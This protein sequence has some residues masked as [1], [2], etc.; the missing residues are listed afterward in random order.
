MNENKFSK[1]KPMLLKEIKEPFNNS[2]YLYELKFDGTRTLIYI[3]NNNILIK[4]RRNVILN[5]VYPELLEIKNITKDKCIFDG[6][7]ILTINGVPNFSKLQERA[8]L[9]NKYKIKYMEDNYPVT[10]VC[11][12][13]LYKNKD[14]TNLT[15]IERKNILNKFK[16]TN[17]FIKSIVYNDGINL[18]KLV[19]LNNLEGIVAKE[20]TSIYK[21][22]IRTS[23]WLKIKNL[24]IEE[25]LICGYI[26][27]L[28]NTISI[29]LGEFKNNKYYYVGK[30]VLSNKHELYEKIIKEKNIS[31]YLENYNNNQVNFIKVKYKINVKY[32]ERTKNNH[33]RNPHI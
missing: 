25:F 4:S 26:K 8:K 27:N 17:V 32:M 9:K 13:I 24:K 15:L 21:Y 14:L 30:V 11:Y 20:K 2:N 7:I 16:D 5:D 22:G 18:F 33:L 23:S 3:E 31:N 12:D 19:K 28:N 10:F 1:L 29:I 6:E